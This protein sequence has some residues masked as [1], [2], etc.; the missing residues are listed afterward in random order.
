V[1]RE[2]SFTAAAERDLRDIYDYAIE[3]T[4]PEHAERLL[5][6]R[7]EPCA[8][9]VSLPERG[10]MPPELR[11]L[12]ITAYREVRVPPYRVIYRVI[13]GGVAIYAIL[14]ARRDVRTLLQRCLLR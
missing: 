13:D 8:S 11:D 9:L 1:T 12:G 2:V 14:D 6:E 3:H 7:E 4:S 5:D 10:N